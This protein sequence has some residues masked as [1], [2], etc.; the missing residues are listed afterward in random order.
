[1]QIYLEGRISTIS[2]VTTTRWMGCP[3]VPIQDRDRL[4]LDGGMD[5]ANLRNLKLVY[6]DPVVR[7]LPPPLPMLAPAANR[8]CT[9]VI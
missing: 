2:G 4:L 5:V 9:P 6:K 3:Q 7:R 8:S 1:M